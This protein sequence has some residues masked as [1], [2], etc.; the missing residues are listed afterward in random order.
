[1]PESGVYNFGIYNQA[2][3]ARKMINRREVR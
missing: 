1:L 2:G 3:S